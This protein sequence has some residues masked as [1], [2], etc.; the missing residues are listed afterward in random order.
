MLLFV[1]MPASAQ[2][3]T[4]PDVSATPTPEENPPAS[5]SWA[6]SKRNQA[7]GPGRSIYGTKSAICVADHCCRP[8]GW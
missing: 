4:A 6:V 3:D 1:S 8:S 7:R 2:T 5:S